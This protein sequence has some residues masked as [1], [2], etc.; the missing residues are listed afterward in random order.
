L[1]TES[2]QADPAVLFST[3]GATA[4]FRF[5]AGST[6]AVFDTPALAFQSGTVSGVLLVQA[7]LSDGPVASHPISV[8]DSAPVIRSVLATR[9]ATGFEVTITGYSTTRELTEARF[10]FGPAPGETLA[11]SEVTIP[12][13]TL[14]EEWYASPESRM[15][16]SQFTYR[17]VFT[18]TGSSSAIASISV[19]LSNTIGD[20]PE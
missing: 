1:T 6:T 9:T 19:K 10:R 8:L 17:Q 7:A 3:G 12:L 2:G 15:F 13:R 16:G 20:S 18:V 11:A 14:A 4:R 5:D